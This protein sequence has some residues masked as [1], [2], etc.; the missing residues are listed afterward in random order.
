[1][2]KSSAMRVGVIAAVQFAVAMAIV[3]WPGGLWAQTE[4]A[5]ASTTP[6]SPASEDRKNFAD[7]ENRRIEKRLAE[8]LPD[9]V[10][11][12]SSAEGPDA[13]YYVWYITP[14]PADASK[15]KGDPE[16]YTSKLIKYGFTKL[17]YEDEKGGSC[18]LDLA[19]GKVAVPSK[20]L[21]PTEE[22]KQIWKTIQDAEAAKKVI[23]AQKAPAAPTPQDAKATKEAPATHTP[24]ERKEYAGSMGEWPKGRFESAEGPDATYYVV[25]TSTYSMDESTCTSFFTDSIVAS[26]REMGFTK[27]VC[28]GKKN[29]SS[30]FDTAARPRPVEAQAP[31]APA[32]G[33][34][35]GG[36]SAVSAAEPVKPNLPPATAWEEGKAVGTFWPTVEQ[37]VDARSGPAKVTG[38]AESSLASKGYVKIGTFFES[39]PG[40]KGNAEVMQELEA[41][42]L[43]KAAEAGGD[44]VRFSSEGTPETREVPTGKTKTK[45]E[46]AETGLVKEPVKTTKSCIATSA[47]PQCSYGTEGGGLVEGCVRF[48]TKEIP[49]TRKE[50]SLVSEGTVWRYDPKLIADIAR[51]AE[52]ARKAEAERVAEELRTAKAA[53]AAAFPTAAAGAFP[54]LGKDINTAEMRTWLSTLGAPKIDRFDDSYYY[55]YKSAGI[56][57]RFSTKGMLTTLFFYAEGADGYRQYQ[58]NLPFGLSFQLTRKEIEGTLGLPDKSRGGDAY[59]WADYSSRG[60]LINYNPKMTNDLNA[61]MSSLVITVP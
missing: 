17:I 28:M 34:N 16:S 35:A 61:R 20:F 21:P 22:A 15:C 53:A 7:A 47:G 56:S 10:S 26:L 8:I 3:L 13:T 49:I 44:V 23:A 39:Q 11:D 14:G 33:E 5:P 51:V 36:S 31:S 25:H 19:A 1:M 4:A 9:A 30:S 59:Y 50:H 48:E 45:K 42:I 6:V 55:S 38:E 2:T 27:V 18:E 37:K 52:T 24:Q 32:A 29:T 58:G 43:K 41:A 54:M 57:L 40:K 60:I 12:I 46:C